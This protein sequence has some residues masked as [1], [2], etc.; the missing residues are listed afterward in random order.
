MDKSDNSKEEYARLKKEVEDEM[1]KNDESTYRNVPVIAIYDVRGIQ[2]YIFRTNKLREIEGASMIVNNIFIDS[3]NEVIK[4]ENKKE[5]SYTDWANNSEYR[6]ADEKTEIEVISSSAGNTTVL[7][8]SGDLCKKI[9]RRLSF[10][11]IDKTYSLNLAIAVIP[12]TDNYK[13]DYTK[14]KIKLG[15]I[16]AKMSYVSFQNSFPL[17]RKD[18]NNNPES[19]YSPYRLK[20]VSQEVYHKLQKLGEVKGAKQLDEMKIEKNIAIVHIDGNGIGGFVTENMKSPTEYSEA[21][22]KIRKTSNTINQSFNIGPIDEAKSRLE[23][24]KKRQAGIDESKSYFREVIN[25]GDDIT[26]VCAAEIAMSLC[27]IYINKLKENESGFTACAGIAYIGSHFPFSSGYEIA[28]KCCDNAKKEMRKKSDKGYWIDFQIVRSMINDFKEYREKNYMREEYSLISRP[29]CMD[30]GNDNF[31]VFKKYIEHFQN[32]KTV[33]KSWCKELRN[34][35][36]T[37]KT[38]A[39]VVTSKMQ[40]RGHRLP[41]DNYDL[42]DETKKTALYFDAL[43]MMELY[44]DI[45]PIPKK[46]DGGGEKS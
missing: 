5:V 4:E 2:A 30:E 11:I 20:W 43:E 6:F 12:K 8:R 37:G 23:E 44:E 29:Y 22:K 42:Y 36:D 25:A 34:A 28:E 1:A 24:W 33:P 9:N 13:N 46:K 31:T 16:K 38:A 19:E 32:P 17:T 27:E 7:F 35:Y 39:S 40:S 45:M 3:L 26:F 10:L 14:L 15:I 18:I 21:V 41:V